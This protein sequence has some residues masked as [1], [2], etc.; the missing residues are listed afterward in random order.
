MRMRTTP[1]VLI[2]ALTAMAAVT[3]CNADPAGHG[4][5]TGVF[6]M[7]GGP[8]PGV[9]I[10]LPGRVIATNRPGQHFTVTV[11]T[12][13]FFTIK[14]PPGTYQLAGYSPRVHV[15]NKEM[16]CTAGHP[17]HVHTG[18]STRSDVYCSVP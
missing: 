6:L 3:G 4:T 2:L 16:R 10:R 13:G 15:N 9:H 1:K 8:G 7:V 18:R 5:V 12:R 14:L 17:V 11:R